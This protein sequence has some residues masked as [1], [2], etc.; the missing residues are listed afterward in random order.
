MGA[1]AVL[2][3]KDKPDRVLHFH[4]GPE[5]KHTVHE[6]ELAGMMLALHLISTEKRNAMSCSIVV[7]NQAALKAFASNMRSPGHHLA[8]KFL[9]LANRMLKRSNKCKY[10]LTL[11]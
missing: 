2:I 10:R 7:D 8:R 9:L 5:S 4:L 1:A 11:R 6:A 3:R